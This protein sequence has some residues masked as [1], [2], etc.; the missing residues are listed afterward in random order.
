[1]TGG[2]ALLDT[3]AAIAFLNN[4]TSAVRAF[5]ELRSPF[6]SPTIY[7]ELLFGARNSSRFH[8][9]RLAISHLVANCEMLLVDNLVAEE[10][11]AIRFELKEKGKPIPENDIWIAATARHHGIPLLTLDAH[12]QQVDRLGL[13]RLS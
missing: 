5:A 11:A 3:S 1:M 12:F 6:L 8:H 9:N 13:I 7:G 4:E 2:S 10:Y